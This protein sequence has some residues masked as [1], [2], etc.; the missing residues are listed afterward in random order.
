MIDKA[1]VSADSGAASTINYA[2][3]LFITIASVFV[4][5]MSNVVFPS[6]S[7]NY[8]EG[9]LDYVKK[10][11]QNMIVIMLSI[12]IPFILVTGCFGESIISLLYERGEFTADLAKTTGILFA[13]YTLG[14]FGYV[15]QE[16]FNKVLYLAG[17]YR[18]TVIGTVVVIALKPVINVYAGK[19]GVVAIAATTTVLFTLYALNIALAMRKIMGKNLYG[20]IFR[21]SLKILLSGIVALAVFVLFRCT[22][23]GLTCGKITFLIPLGVCGVIYCAGLLMSG[24]VKEIIKGTK[25]EESS[26]E[27]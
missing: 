7:K 9:N 27:Q 21:S 6:I 18:Y 3:N 16:L 15:C 25:A 10:L 14:A 26:K 8:E 23:P 1:F 13:V 24:I 11:L 12:F 4:V 5:A 22:Y 19:Y 2:S 17:K 20:S